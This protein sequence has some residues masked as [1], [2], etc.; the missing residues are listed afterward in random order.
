MMLQALTFETDSLFDKTGWG[1][2]DNQFNMQQFSVKQMR[3]H[4]STKKAKQPNSLKH[5]DELLPDTTID[6]GLRWKTLSHHWIDKKSASIV[7]KMIHLIKRPQF[8]VR[9]HQCPNNSCG[10]IHNSNYVHACFTCPI[11]QSVWSHAVKLWVKTGHQPYN[12]F[13]SN[14]LI[15]GLPKLEKGGP[16]PEAP[17]GWTVIHTTTV[18]C[19]WVAWCSHVHENTPYNKQYL[20]NKL[21][22]LVTERL[23]ILWKRSVRRDIEQSVGKDSVVDKAKSEFLNHWCSNNSIIELNTENQK[24]KIDF[25]KDQNPETNTASGSSTTNDHENTQDQTTSFINAGNLEEWPGL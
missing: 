14:N 1:E 13:S 19:L 17:L 25:S 3:S 22:T 10:Q 2:G 5:W 20:I 21:T 11:A 15:L 16:S 18:R 23:E 4:I 6:W 9:P 24:I 12:Q 7:L 8:A